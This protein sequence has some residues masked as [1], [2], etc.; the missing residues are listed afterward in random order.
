MLSF[1]TST[2]QLSLLKDLLKLLQV[3]TARI[4]IWE[5]MEWQCTANL[6]GDSLPDSF[7]NDSQPHLPGP[8]DISS[9]ESPLPPSDK[10]GPN[11]LSP[12]TK[13]TG[14]PKQ[15]KQKSVLLPISESVSDTIYLNN[16]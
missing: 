10:K 2:T 3:E 9:H 14:K 11:Q 1:R 16:I 13:K 8:I 5:E 7:S 6:S 12:N 4:A 15:Q